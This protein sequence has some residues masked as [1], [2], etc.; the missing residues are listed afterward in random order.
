M[1][2]H[3]ATLVPKLEK[4]QAKEHTAQKVMEQLDG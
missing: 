2:E 3:P 4:Y 1:V